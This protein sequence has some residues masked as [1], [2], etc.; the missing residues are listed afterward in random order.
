MLFLFFARTRKKKVI[1]TTIQTLYCL[2]IHTLVTYLFLLTVS[3]FQLQ[4]RSAQ[5]LLYIYF[6]TALFFSSFLFFCPP[7]ATLNCTL[8]DRVAFA[9][10]QFTGDFSAW[11]R[12]VFRLALPS[13]GCE[14][15]TSAAACLG[16][17]EGGGGYTL[18]GG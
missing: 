8:D 12:Q 1:I 5:L 7:L 14:G 4:G 3:L 6:K 13:V 9:P 10:C 2:S 17:V 16:G 18:L 11:E 15:F